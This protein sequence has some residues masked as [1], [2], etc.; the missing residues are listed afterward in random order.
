MLDIGRFLP[1]DEERVVT[2]TD[3]SPTKT[4]THSPARGEEGTA[5]NESDI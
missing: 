5:T 2:G 3:S 1:L 4:Y